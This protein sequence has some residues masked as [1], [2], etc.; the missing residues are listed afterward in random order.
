M[1]IYT[2]WTGLK[3]VF[4][5]IFVGLGN[6]DGIHVGHQKLIGNLVRQARKAGGTSVVFTFVP[7][8]LA[9]L[10]PKGAPPLILPPDVKREMFA[11]LGVDV[12][13]WV[14]FSL[15]FARL[16]P[17]D[18]IK[19]VLHEQLA[20]RTVLVGYN[21][22]F[23]YK[24]RGTPELLKEYGAHLDFAVEMLQPIKVDGQP[25]SST[26]IRNMLA[27]GK[28]S[29]ARKY[30][31]YAPIIKGQVVYG[32]SRGSTLGFPTANIEV[33]PDLLVPGNG[34]YSVTVNLEGKLH[35]GIANIGAKPTFHDNSF[36][37]SI[38]VHILDFDG[39]LY[40]KEIQVCFIKRVRSEK[41]FSGV[42][43]LVQQIKNDI[44]QVRLDIKE[45]S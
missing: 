40:D 21:Y 27:D 34:V 13:L 44:A 31:G 22:T 11:K 8:P 32:E 28:I 25:V 9:I 20:V 26:L 45:E 30:L 42:E 14:P 19:Q 3:D 10:S 38:E 16:S 6:F 43:E 7:H 15:E 35:H 39:N 4:K 18:F 41:K 5:D 2:D 37:R 33:A 12:L 36:N 29:E 17:E 23:G 1:H 24:G